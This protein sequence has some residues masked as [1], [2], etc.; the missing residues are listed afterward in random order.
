M[1]TAKCDYI[2]AE[3]ERDWEFCDHGMKADNKR[4]RYS[5]LDQV[6]IYNR[7]TD[8]GQTEILDIQTDTDRQLK[9]SEPVCDCAN[10]TLGW[11]DGCECALKISPER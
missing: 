10:D 1:M 3:R 11:W 8:N 7:D 5:D 6:N 2:R 9:T 4:D